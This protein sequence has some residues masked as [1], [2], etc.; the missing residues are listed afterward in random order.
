M[1]KI[2]T[3]QLS[4]IEE[5]AED[6]ECFLSENDVDMSIIFTMNLCLDEIFTNII[7]YG[8]KNEADGEIELNLELKNDN[9]I[10]LIR[11]SS[12]EFDP[13]SQAPEADITSPIEDREIGGLG[14]FLCQ[15]NMDTFEYRRVGNKNE[16]KL[17]KK[18][19]LA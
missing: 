13:T 7:S 1:K 3:S 10:A 2:Y 17:S 11:D 12:P 14:I 9:I 5:M 15:K 19:C 18:L 6:T 16:L 4:S 8:Y